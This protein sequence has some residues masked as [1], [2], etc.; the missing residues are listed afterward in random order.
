M[1][2]KNCSDEEED[3]VDVCDECVEEF[4]EDESSGFVGDGK[5]VQC[6][7]RSDQEK[8]QILAIDEED[9]DIDYEDGKWLR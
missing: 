5:E 7:V 6:L 9:D 1:I 8:L 4:E 3:S 2:N